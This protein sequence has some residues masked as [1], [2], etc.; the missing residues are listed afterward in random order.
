M[1]KENRGGNRIGNK[2]DNKKQAIKKFMESLKCTESHYCRSKTFSRIYL[3]AEL[4]FV[5]LWRIYNETVG[6]DEA[7]K[8][9]ESFFRAYVN[10]TFNIGFGT[11]KTD[12]CSTCLQFKTNIK[13]TQDDANKNNLIAQ[14]RLHKIRANCFYALL[15]ETREDLA[16]FS[17]DCQKNLAVPKLP[18]QSAY[19]SMQ[20]NFYHLA[21]V[22]GS[23]KAKL[24]QENVRSYVWTEIDHQRSSNEISSALHHTLLQFNFTEKAKV[25]RLI[26]DGCGAQN[27]NSTVI[28]MLVYWLQ[29]EAPPQIKNVELIFPV[30]GHSY[31]PPDRVFGQIE[32]IY[33]KQTEFVHPE[34]YVNILNKFA[35]VFKIGNEVKI[36][37]WRSE[38]QKVLKQPGYWHFKFQPSKRIMFSKN[39]TNVL[40][41]GE[42]F[43]KNSFCEP[44]SLCKRGKKV[45]S[46]RP[47]QLPV[48]VPVKKDKKASIKKLL[49]AHYGK[50]W[51]KEAKLVFFKT[52]FQDNLE[53]EEINV[54]EENQCE[55]ENMN[56]AI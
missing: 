18:D 4:S 54:I 41:S 27:K 48:G 22:C 38:S 20:I 19:F 34:E 6:N 1:P 53:E 42:A 24:N 52:V 13:K 40:V 50:E 9:K 28:G 25:V 47:E 16:T 15:Q 3:P 51:E 23:S 46:M 12:I 29:C 5:R 7:L 30:V 37:D 2:N 10:K 21:I 39:G 31:I 32:R 33:K 44:K 8:V 26:C 35:T 49:E 55:E 45:A 43:Y 36:Q 17:F 56:F 11:P 14:Q